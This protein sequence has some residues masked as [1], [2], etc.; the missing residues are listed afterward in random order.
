VAR[1]R[2]PGAVQ[3]ELTE[4]N[5][6]DRYS[7]DSKRLA[8]RTSEGVEVWRLDDAVL[9]AT[10]PLGAE[11]S[12][13]VLS[14]DWSVTAS[15]VSSSTTGTTG[16]RLLGTTS[17]ALL[18]EMATSSWRA[19]PILSTD[20]S[21]VAVTDYITHTHGV[22]WEALR[23]VD[24]PTGVTQRQFGANYGSGVAAF[25]RDGAR[26]F[27]LEPPVVAVWCR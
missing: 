14:P 4:G 26:L 1:A 9:D 2:V 19:P 11:A 7:P 27:T 8:V 6:V 13:A 3:L 5:G 20:G 24:A 23:I 17:G 12:S 10:Y 18:A 22:D 21:I 16:L 25:G 15:I